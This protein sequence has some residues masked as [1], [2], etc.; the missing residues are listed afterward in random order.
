M[1][2]LLHRGSERAS[3]EWQTLREKPSSEYN[4]RHHGT[5]SAR[6]P[7]SQ[8]QGRPCHSNNHT[9]WQGT[10]PSLRKTEEPNVPSD[11]PIEFSLEFPVSVSF[12]ELLYLEIDDTRPWVTKNFPA[13]SELSSTCYDQIR[14]VT[15]ILSKYEQINLILNEYKISICIKAK[16]KISKTIGF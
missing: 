1:D 9:L 6:M 15:L 14:G 13:R 16:V 12:C 4:V 3:G 5:D 11:S 8:G 2:G 7:E 10:K